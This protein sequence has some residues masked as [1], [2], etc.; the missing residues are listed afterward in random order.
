MA[1]NSDDRQLVKLIFIK[2]QTNTVD[3]FIQKYIGLK[4]HLFFLNHLSFTLFK[5]L[6]NKEFYAQEL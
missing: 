2:K 6:E 4:F 1:N 3:F 5:T